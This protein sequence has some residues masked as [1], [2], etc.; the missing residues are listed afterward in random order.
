MSCL[1]LCIGN[2]ATLNLSKLQHSS[3]EWFVYEPGWEDCKQ[4]EQVNLVDFLHSCMSYVRK[5][6]SYWSN[7]LQDML[8]DINANLV[9]TDEEVNGG[10]GRKELYAIFIFG[11]TIFCVRFCERHQRMTAEEM[12]TTVSI[13]APDYEAQ[14]E[15]YVH[16]IKAKGLGAF[17]WTPIPGILTGERMP[18]QMELM[19]MPFEV[20][21]LM[22]QQ[23]MAEPGLPAQRRYR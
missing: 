9:F 3:R 4:E 1:K 16:D 12:A 17:R 21:R 15:A 6:Y 19:Q 7:E 14:M 10:T 13:S 8:R 20:L 23:A 11:A 2:N 22:M 5:M 18:S